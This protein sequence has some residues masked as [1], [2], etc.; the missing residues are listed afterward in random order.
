MPDFPIVLVIGIVVVLGALVVAGLLIGPGES[1]PDEMSRDD[2]DDSEARVAASDGPDRRAGG[3]GFRSAALALAHGRGAD[4]P[5]RRRHRARHARSLNA[6]QSN[7]VSELGD[8]D[9][10]VSSSRSQR[11]SAPE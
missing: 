5:R 10:G 11:S 4:S 8:D 7:A 2:L 3:P 9:S 1:A 6:V